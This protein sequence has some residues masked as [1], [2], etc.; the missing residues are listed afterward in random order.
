[1]TE[2]QDV[3]RVMEHPAEAVP[4]ERLDYRIPLTFG[5]FLDRCADIAEARARLD[6]L[7]AAHHAFVG[8]VH[9]TH[10]LTL[11]LA[12]RIHA[13]RVAM[14]AVHDDGDVD[15]DDVAFLELPRCRNAMAHDLVDRCADR[16]PVA[17][18]EQAG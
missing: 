15:V 4:A 10:A 13:R 14:P 17:L 3:R 9:K 6:C 7:D 18:V 16:V 2:V 8:D 5:V 1:T 12:H 11:H